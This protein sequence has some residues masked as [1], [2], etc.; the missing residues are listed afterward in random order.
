MSSDL[1]GGLSAPRLFGIFFIGCISG[2]V[3][4]T[5]WFFITKGVFESRK[6]LIYGPFNLVYGIGAVV[7]TLV[8]YRARNAGIVLQFALGAAS[9]CLVEYLCSFVQEALFGTVSWQYDNSK[10]NLNGRVDLLHTF[11][12]GLLAVVWIRYV[13][14]F[15]FSWF[16][17]IPAEIVTPITCSLAIFML[18]DSCLSGCAVYRMAERHADIPANNKVAELL[19]E[20][21]PDERLQRIYTNMEFVK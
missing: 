16:D 9:G 13:L 18:I 14:P 3:L 12:W 5:I 21:Y 20:K 1:S 2:V 11:Y 17:R 10:F 19:D 4:E 8:L 6:G 15:I 7:L